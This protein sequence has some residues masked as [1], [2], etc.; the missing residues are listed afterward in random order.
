ML[1]GEAA[2]VTFYDGYIFDTTARKNT[3]AAQREQSRGVVSHRRAIPSMSSPTIR[4]PARTSYL[5]YALKARP[6]RAE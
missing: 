4:G 3:D 1:R 6:H 5:C 2:Q